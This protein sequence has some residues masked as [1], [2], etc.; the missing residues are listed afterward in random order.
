MP[1]NPE[2]Q[3]GL[4]P[5]AAPGPDA[6]G[7]VC[8]CCGLTNQRIGGRCGRCETPLSILCP[9]CGAPSPL[10]ARFCA[11]CGMRLA[12]VFKAEAPHQP[13][14][15]QAKHEL[16]QLTVLFADLVGSSALAAAL[17]P[18]EF[19]EIV[20]L[21]FRAVSA[22]VTHHG[23]YFGRLVGDAAFVYFGYP[24]SQEDDA[25][26][27]VRAALATVQAVALLPPCRGHRLQVR[28]GLSNGLVMV[29]DPADTG[30]PRNTDFYGETPNLAA[31]LQALAAPGAILASDSVRRLVGGCFEFHGCGPQ[32]IK[33]W[34]EP[35][36]VWQVLRPCPN[37]S[38][39]EARKGGTAAP[40]L[41]RDA[42]LDRLRSLWRAA[43][44]GKG[45]VVLVTGEA[46]I[47][48]SR[49][50]A[51][52][53]REAP[54]EAHH[55]SY[56][57]PH[58]QA[59][60]LRPTI[61]HLEH[62]SGIAS[63]DAPAQRLAKLRALLPDSS[64]TDMA[65]IADLLLIRDGSL[66]ALPPMAPQRRRER[67]LQALFGTFAAAAR[68]RPI[69]AVCEDAHWAD[70][71]TQKLLDMTAQGIAGLPVLLVVTARPEYCADWIREPGAECLTLDQLGP[72]ES[73]AL[74]RAIARDV[75]LPLRTVHDLV[76]RSDGLPLYLEELT[77]AVTESITQS[78]VMAGS[79]GP[80]TGVPASLQASLLARLDRLGPAREVAEV[81]AVIGREFDA[82]F[83]A[84]VLGCGEAYVSLLLERLRDAG[85]VLRGNPRAGATH[86]F[87]HML[88]REAAQGMI[89]RD[90]Y[91]ALHARVADLLEA[92]NLNGAATTQPHLLA[93]HRT[94]ARQLDRAVQWWLRSAQQML[95][96][97]AVEEALVQLRR[98]LSLVQELPETP[99]RHQVELEM[100]LLVGN[101][102]L[103]TKGHAA[104]ETGEAFAH[105]RTICAKLPGTPLLMN[106]MHGQWAHAL[107]RGELRQAERQA[108]DLL[109]I[110]E[111]TGADAWLLAGWRAIGITSYFRGG[112]GRSVAS[113]QR[114]IGFF[115]PAQRQRYSGIT[116]HDP[117][118]NIR[119]YVS[120]GR[121]WLG[122]LG[123]ARREAADALQV[124]HAIGHFY[125]VAHALFTVA[126]IDL[127]TGW[128]EQGLAGMQE[129]LRFSEAHGVPYFEMVSKIFCGILVARN[130]GPEAGLA[131]VRDGIAWH[132]A[133]DSHSYLPG[134]LAS[135]GELMALAGDPAG[136]LS[137]FDE[138]FM[139]MD[140]SD[141]RWDE[142][143]LHRQQGE[144]HRLAGNRMEAEAALR[145]A[146]AI[147]DASGARLRRLQCAAALAGLLSGDGR[148]EAARMALA[149]VL[150][151]FA[152]EDA[153]ILLRARRLLD[154]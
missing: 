39:F 124:A 101:A 7:G 44:A 127:N 8:L 139:R 106:S 80:R 89:T 135:E 122:D 72:E 54:L 77:W 48:K 145:R 57:A 36:A 51:E 63:G 76:Q 37:V 11:G 125:T 82:A 25:D 132:R 75:P 119:C 9:G 42:P 103:A 126:Y 137:R 3:N 129:S 96:R 131:M 114:A 105:A 24:T 17:D 130:G 92:Q 97:S 134:F 53:L 111:R 107:M 16:R 15:A 31:R 116:V 91:R 71:A 138:A 84:L 141:A 118:I 26:Q 115:D 110:G 2:Q 64:A 100:Q 34:P 146:V 98:G 79:R 40:M 102:L 81:A 67:L 33:G 19:A 90:R 148:R 120:W 133:T 128:E 83:L 142:A 14:A 151:G 73:A 59:M 153:P 58:Q 66:P 78:E 117:E 23:G 60:A 38:R 10:A 20:G 150:A 109:D 5:A 52:L 113:L 1:L 13:A 55:W 136:G 144:V 46:G 49:L 32:P 95:L 104:P 43:Q 69:L 6:V 50:V 140:A 152:G 35:I 70:P 27:A 143:E 47:G 123:A 99:A 85:I 61:N 121:M 45:R 18:E 22:A 30:D 149:P 41:G 12:T 65:L 93:H 147:A 4:S 112:F 56:A 86:R 74:V 21:F 154:D 94:E 28:I 88:L 29:G 68:R 87:K 62:N 108:Q